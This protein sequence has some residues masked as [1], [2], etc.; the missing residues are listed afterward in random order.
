MSSSHRLA[1]GVDS[2]L[3]ACFLRKGVNRRERSN[4]EL[5]KYVRAK[6]RTASRW[7]QYSVKAREFTMGREGLNNIS[8]SGSHWHCLGGGTEMQSFARD[9]RDMGPPRVSPATENSSPLTSPY[10]RLGPLS[11]KISPPLPVHIF[12]D[13]WQERSRS[14]DGCRP[15][16]LRLL[17][18]PE[19]NFGASQHEFVSCKIYL[20]ILLF[21][22]RSYEREPGR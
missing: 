3:N 21:S 22:L 6:S 16:R 4:G 12:E 10:L 9:R 14:D 11:R 5:S 17:P 2:V 7:R 18:L 20:P 13:T 15:I 1:E 8:Y 19:S